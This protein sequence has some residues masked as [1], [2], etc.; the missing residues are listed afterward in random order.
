MQPC[1]KGCLGSRL[2]A[3]GLT[4]IPLALPIGELHLA[5]LRFRGARYDVRVHNRGPFLQEFRLNG[6]ILRG[7]CK[8]P[9]GM[10]DPGKNSIDIVYG[11]EQPEWCFREIVNAEVLE[12]QD[13]E[14]RLD[15]R[16]RA[17]GVVDLHLFSPVTCEL[18]LDNVPLA[19]AWEGG[20]HTMSRQL[21]I[22]GDHALSLVRR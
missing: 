20:I 22:H 3:E 2:T 21:F 11:P 15:I 13:A 12:V 4:I 1:S 7:C 19:T 14:D 18:L 17:H 6:R 16:I 5:G 8:L 10:V 9:S